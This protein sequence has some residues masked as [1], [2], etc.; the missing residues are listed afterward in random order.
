MKTNKEASTTANLL[1]AYMRFRAEQEGVG[2]ELTP[3]F[4]KGQ[5]FPALAGSLVLLLK[6]AS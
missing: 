3:K 4:L 6:T 1:D 5:C 2:Y